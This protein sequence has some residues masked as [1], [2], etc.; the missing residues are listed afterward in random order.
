MVSC[1]CPTYNRFPIDA[2]MLDECVYWFTKQTYTGERELIILNDNP[3][4][5]LTCAT[6]GVMVYNESLRYPSLGAKYNR[7]LELAKGDIILPWEDDDI[8]LPHRIEQSVAVL[9]SFKKSY[10]NPKMAFFQNGNRAELTLCSPNSVHHNAS[11][12]RRTA[13]RYPEDC[14]QDTG[15]DQLLAGSVPTITGLLAHLTPSYVYRWQCAAYFGNLSGY[16]DPQKAYTDY[17]PESHSSSSYNIVPTMHRDY[18]AEGETLW[19][20]LYGTSEYIA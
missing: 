8:S 3:L 2:W 6:P 16:Y 1:I 19:E 7:L 11:A 13:L 14:K 5:K 10:W 4:Q 20:K 12:F 9:D 17:C 18:Q 15:M